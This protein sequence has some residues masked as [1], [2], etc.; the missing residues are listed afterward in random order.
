[1]KV[2]DAGTGGN[3]E[4]E[5][6][7]GV[8]RSAGGIF[9]G[10]GGGPELICLLSGRWCNTYHGVSELGDLGVARHILGRASKKIYSKE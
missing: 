10:D 6:D 2:G 8:S 3:W 4:G 5:G 7:G 1:V 9:D